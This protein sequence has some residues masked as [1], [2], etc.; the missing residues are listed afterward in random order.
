MTAAVRALNKALNQ[1]RREWIEGSDSGRSGMIRALAAACDFIS[2]ADRT[3]ARKYSR[4]HM[5]LIAALHDLN[6]GTVAPFLKPTNIGRGRRT[7]WSHRQL[8]WHAAATMASLM[9]LGRQREDVK[10]SR[11]SAAK[12]AADVLSRCGIPRATPR[13]VANCYDIEKETWRAFYVAGT[14]EL[15]ID[16]MRRRLNGP[17]IRDLLLN[18]LASIARVW[19][20][21]GPRSQGH[22][23]HATTSAAAA[24]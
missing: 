17:K 22:G 2:A 5:V 21:A 4:F 19:K 6:E 13:S 16:G 11:R 12:L 8:L 10:I 1:A 24:T 15:V 14:H 18:D 7:G 3:C 9:D 23:L 20:A